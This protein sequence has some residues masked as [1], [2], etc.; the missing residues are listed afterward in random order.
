MVGLITNLLTIFFVSWDLYL[1]NRLEYD[2]IS[3]RSIFNKAA[4]PLFILVQLVSH[5]SAWTVIFICIAEW[6]FL[7]IGLTILLSW[8][9]TWLITKKIIKNNSTKDHTSWK[10]CWNSNLEQQPKSIKSVYWNTILTSWISPCSIYFMTDNFYKQAQNRQD[11]KQ[12]EQDLQQKQVIQQKQQQQQHQQQQQQQKSKRQKQHQPNRTCSTYQ[13]SNDQQQQTP[14]QQFELKP[15]QKPNQPTEDQCLIDQVHQPQPKPVNKQKVSKRLLF[16]VINSPMI[17]Q[18]LI[19]SAIGLTLSY[20]NLLQTSEGGPIT[21]C[22]QN[23]SSSNS[24]NQTSY[25][26]VKPC[27]SANDCQ[28]NLRFCEEGELPMDLVLKTIIPIIILP[29]ILLSLISTIA[30]QQM[31][32]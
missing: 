25:G 26:W 7:C 23:T 19:I 28:N 10:G 9:I 31:G 32:N 29:M 12:Q 14:Q 18:L 27:L 13:A 16:V 21:H 2:P 17:I 1:Q 5:M 11:K 6:T 4:I 15:E 8:L 24:T 3:E 30:L 20:S 22:C